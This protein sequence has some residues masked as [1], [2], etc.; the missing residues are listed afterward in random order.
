MRI[1]RTIAASAAALLSAAGT[2]A[3]GCAMCYS[4]AS[5]SGAHAQKSLDWGIFILLV[6]SLVLFG[7]VF[8]MLH[9]RG[10]PGE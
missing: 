6:P 9:R 10:N 1:V 7:S 2:F 8:F 5:A 3:Q 4:Q